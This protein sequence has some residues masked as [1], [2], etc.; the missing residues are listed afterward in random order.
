MTSIFFLPLHLGVVFSQEPIAHIGTFIVN[1]PVFVPTHEYWSVFGS[2]SGWVFRISI[3][4][5]SLKTFL[6]RSLFHSR[7][8]LVKRLFLTAP[9]MKSAPLKVLK[10]GLLSD[11][12]IYGI[13][14]LL[15]M[16]ARP[17]PIITL[18]PCLRRFATVTIS[19][20][21]I[22][23]SSLSLGY[24]TSSL[25]L[26]FS[27]IIVVN[28]A[29]SLLIIFHPHNANNVV[30]KFV[31]FLIPSP[32]KRLGLQIFSHFLNA[33]N[34]F[35]FQTHWSTKIFSCFVYV[36]TNTLFF[37]NTKDRQR[38]REYLEVRKILD[39]P[40]QRISDFPSTLHPCTFFNLI[41]LFI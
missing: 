22:E 18:V 26:Y 6:T 30:L 40:W 41:F 38:I 39:S 25:I 23:L 36:I 12:S 33:R 8:F 27:R 3:A 4:I 34:E 15:H 35:F 2:I 32:P 24:M 17:S 37:C 19:F 9:L 21:T 20:P 10:E 11:V 5:S 28:I 29:L 13:H 7:P 31:V 16:S 1:C 14:G